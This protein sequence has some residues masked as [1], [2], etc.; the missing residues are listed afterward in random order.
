[1]KT[2]IYQFWD[3]VL[4]SGNKAGTEFMK[5]YAERIGSEYLFE[6]NARFRTDLGKFSP[7]YGA[8]KPIFNKNFHEYDYILFT[9]T[10]VVPV[11]GL[12]ENIFDEL[13]GTDFDIGICEEWNQPEQREKY[14]G[15][16]SNAA[17]NRW[18][19]LIESNWGCKMPRDEKN[20]PRVF[21]SGVVVYSKAGREKFRKVYIPF[22]DYIRKMQSTNLASFYQGDQNYLNAILY[23]FKWKLMDYKWNSSVHYSVSQRGGAHRPVTDLRNGRANFVHQQLSAADHY[24]KDTVWRVAN[25][26]VSEWKQHG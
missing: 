5:E 10:D 8:F 11:D 18:C 23:R 15:H 24:D 7:H 26:P 9:D 17:D 20:R 13:I 1:M 21:N 6:H 14:P 19:D 2:L 22:A 4:T 12:T 25:L 16:I 3:G